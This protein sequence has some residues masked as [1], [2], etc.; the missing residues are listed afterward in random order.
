MET[1]RI[2]P[3][4]RARLERAWPDILSAM[5]GGLPV[6]DALKAHGL[7]R[8]ALAVALADPAMRAQWEGAKEASADE[9]FDRLTA[10]SNNHAADVDPARARVVVDLLKWLAAKRNPRAYADQSRL[11]VNV[12]TIDLTKIIQDANARLIAAR[13]QPVTI[14]LEPSEFTRLL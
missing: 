14:D 12:R 9:F 6:G 1:S 10:M 3:E 4:T 13:A 11:D 8:A 5:A 7:T 2:G